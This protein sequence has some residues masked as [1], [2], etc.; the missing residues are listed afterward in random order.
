LGADLHK[1]VDD[2]ADTVREIWDAE[3]PHPYQTLSF[4]ESIDTEKVPIRIRRR[5]RTR[6]GKV[7]STDE[8]APYVEYGT[9]DTPEFGP[10]A[11]AAMRYK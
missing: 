1:K 6:I 7:E 4:R 8:V 5:G 3:G 9:D 11:L 10:F 2:V